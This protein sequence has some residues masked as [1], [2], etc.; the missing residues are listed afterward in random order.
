MKHVHY[1]SVTAEA[2]EQGAKDVKIRW[3]IT[4]QDGATNFVMRHFEIGPGGHT[5][6]HEHPWEHEV[7]ILTGSGVATG[8]GGEE[9]F[10]PGDVFLVPGGEVHQFRNTGAESVTML[11]LIPAREQALAGLAILPPLRGR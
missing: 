9:A 6:H 1:S 7:F 5:P 2:V 8:P 3:L 11:C 10:G 4:E